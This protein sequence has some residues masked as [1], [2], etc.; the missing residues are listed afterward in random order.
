MSGMPETSPQPN[1]HPG[2]SPSRRLD[3]DARREQLVAVGLELMRSIPFDRITP[4]EVARRAGVSKGLVF[5]YFAGKGDLQAAVLRAA[6]E[7]L[8]AQLDVDP[9]LAPGERLRAGLDAFVSYIEQHP[10]NYRA[11]SRRA[12][13]DARLLAVFEDTRAAIVGLIGATFGM[14]DLTPGLRI[15][16]RGWIAMVE[17]SVLCWL[18]G[19]RTVEREALLGFLERSAMVMLPHALATFLPGLGAWAQLAGGAARGGPA[20]GGPAYGGAAYGG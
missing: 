17:E 7:D 20:R 12:G 2:S 11:I 16:V 10:D 15:L 13:S 8:L 3:P 9:A 5:H 4:D 6:A 14:P 1:P 18:E 19:G